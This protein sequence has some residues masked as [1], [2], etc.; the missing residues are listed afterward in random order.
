MSLGVLKPE[1]LSTLKAS[2]PI[3]VLFAPSVFALSA[4]YP[5]AVELLAVVRAFPALKPTNVVAPVV[6][7]ID[8]PASYPIAT[9]SE[10]VEAT[11]KASNPIAIFLS[12]S[13]ILANAE[14]PTATLY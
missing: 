5:N 1:E 14:T 9:L 8:L 7:V 3:A 6:V 2:L 4:L 12:P 10:E 13:V 11:L